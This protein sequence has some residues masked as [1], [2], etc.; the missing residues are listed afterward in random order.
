MDHLVFLI[1]IVI[2][3]CEFITDLLCIGY[4]D[5]DQWVNWILQFP[6]DEVTELT[7]FSIIPEELDTPAPHSR[8]A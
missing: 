7:K 8:L 2:I 1:L 4:I 5:A 6:E 3:K